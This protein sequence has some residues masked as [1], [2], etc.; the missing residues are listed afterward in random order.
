MLGLQS[1]RWFPEKIVNVAAIQI[2]LGTLTFFTFV[3][4]ARSGV[5]SGEKSEPWL[6]R[7]SVQALSRQAGVRQ[8]LIDSRQIPE[9]DIAIVAGDG[10]LFAVRVPRDPGN[11]SVITR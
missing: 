11:G 3:M 5:T 1:A 6:H 7:A 2:V 8:G 10:E 9:G 4:A